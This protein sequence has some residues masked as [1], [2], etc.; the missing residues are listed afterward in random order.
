MKDVDKGKGEE[1][2]SSAID[3]KET[4]D[5]TEMSGVSE[6]LWLKRRG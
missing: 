4:I 2:E 5:M 3:E 1:L 6:M